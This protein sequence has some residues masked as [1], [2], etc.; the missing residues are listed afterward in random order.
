MYGISPSDPESHSLLAENEQLQFELLSDW[1][2]QFGE[3]FEF[4]D[5]EEQLIY[6]GYTA[7]NAETESQVTEVDYLVGEN[8]D[9]VL[10]VLSEL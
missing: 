10:E 5:V 9:E 6:R 4:V 7:V 3:H 2:V 1:E 8:V